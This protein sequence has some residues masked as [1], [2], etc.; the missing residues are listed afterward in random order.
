LIREAATGVSV[1]PRLATFCSSSRARR[2]VL[3]AE[4]ACASFIE[5][6]SITSRSGFS[7]SSASE[8]EDGICVEMPSRRRGERRW[9]TVGS[10]GQ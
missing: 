4:R 8:E 9:L 6:S 7:V 3:V 5:R 10:G 2:V 1:M